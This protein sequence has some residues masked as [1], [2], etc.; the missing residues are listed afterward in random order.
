MD[1]LIGENAD[2]V[3]VLRIGWIGE[4]WCRGSDDNVGL[5]WTE[6]REGPYAKKEA[7]EDARA[8]L[9]FDVVERKR[10]RRMGIVAKGGKLA[11]VFGAG[12]AKFADNCQGL[13]HKMP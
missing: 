9:V 7:P 2:V 11:G 13:A 8:D 10:I 4:G 6:L 5:A 1:N 3:D 12:K